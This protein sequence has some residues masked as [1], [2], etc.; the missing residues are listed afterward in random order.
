MTDN[1]ERESV[2]AYLERRASDDYSGDHYR[3]RL[4][5]FNKTDGY[6]TYCKNP[7]GFDWEADHVVPRSQG[8]TNAIEN[9][10]PSCRPCNHEKS[11]RI[12]WRK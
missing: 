4:R 12:D 1:G 2:R 9:M 8:G 7:L 6:C 5:I 3:R 10:A 11:D